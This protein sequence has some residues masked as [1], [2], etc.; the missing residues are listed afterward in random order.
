METPETRYSRSADGVHIAYQVL[1]DADLDIVLS[2]GFVSHLEHSWEDP[3]MARFLRRLASFSRLIVFDKR[4][5]GLSDR[6]T[7]DRPGLLEDRVRDIATLMDTVGSERAAIMGLSETGAVALLFAAMHPERTRAVVVYGSYT[8]LGDK[9][10]IY[11]WAPDPEEAALLENLERNWGRG[12]LY[13][14]LFAPS[15]VGDKRYEDWFA[16][17]E[18]LSVSPG[19]AVA[20]VR[21][22][23]EMDVRDILPAIRVPTLVLHKRDDK[24]VPIDEGRRIAEG[25]PGAKFVELAG[26]DHWPWIGHEDAVEEIQEFLTGM[27]DSIEPDRALVTVMFVDI[28][29]S[30]KRA[31]ELGDRRW[32]DLLESFYAVVRRDLNRYGGREVDTAGDGLFAIFDGPVRAIRC[33]T[34]LTE[35]IVSL[36]LHIRTGIHTGECERIGDNL[37]GLSVVIGARVGALAGPGEILVSRTVQDLVVGSG[38]IFEDAG[39]HELKGVPDRWRLYRVVG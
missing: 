34:A 14:E 6:T 3:S 7:N 22:L 28:V 4:G 9:G 26:A 18:R 15:L 38:L 36:G 27:R 8:G 13:L 39:E 1:G 24:V 31:A 12:A 11:P 19:A 30:T 16:K 37:R 23:L 25:V 17:L 32:T 21:M 35:A 29:D 33:A 20:G 5:T 2:P 10:P